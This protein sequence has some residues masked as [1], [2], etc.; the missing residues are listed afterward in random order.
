[1]RSHYST[2]AYSQNADAVGPVLTRDDLIHQLLHGT[3]ARTASIVNHL[4]NSLVILAVWLWDLS[5]SPL[6]VLLIVPMFFSL[7]VAAV[8][9]CVYQK[10]RT[11][12]GLA[13]CTA[14]L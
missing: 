6:V 5:S 2:Q 13:S 8:R 11:F 12:L 1:M 14:L 3:A 4:E 7:V 10:Q 9:A